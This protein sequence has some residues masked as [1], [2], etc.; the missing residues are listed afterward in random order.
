[1]GPFGV[2]QKPAIE[3]P[4]EAISLVPQSEIKLILTHQTA[5]RKN[6][7][8]WWW[9][10]SSLLIISWLIL[11]WVR[12]LGQDSYLH[13][14]QSG[15]CMGSGC[16]LAPISELYI[17]LQTWHFNPI[18]IHM[19][20]A[21]CWEPLSFDLPICMPLWLQ[22]LYA[23]YHYLDVAHIIQSSFAQ[24]FTGWRGSG[25]TYCRMVQLS[26]HGQVMES[27]AHTY[28][29]IGFI[30]TYRKMEGAGGKRELNT[31]SGSLVERA[32][33][34]APHRLICESLLLKQLCASAHT[35]CRRRGRSAFTH[36][37]INKPPET[38]IKCWENR[39]YLHVKLPGTLKCLAGATLWASV[40]LQILSS[41]RGMIMSNYHSCQ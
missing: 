39:H 22:Q 24:S 40:V 20:R 11:A 18:C 9:R 41:T 1:M 17:S 31:L 37:H 15:G 33:G 14:H 3:P 30:W 23:W 26:K 21:G 32:T 6:S 29:R 34:L 16:S 25:R 27:N 7:E 8:R 4:S 36:L 35:L 38:F 5:Q 2:L 19:A 10:P 13:K 12:W 28:T